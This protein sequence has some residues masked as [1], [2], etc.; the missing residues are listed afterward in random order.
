MNFI[1]NEKYVHKN[2]K[3]YTTIKNTNRNLSFSLIIL[4]NTKL[5]CQELYLKEILYKNT[6][7]NPIL[8]FN[9]NNIIRLLFVFKYRV[10][11]KYSS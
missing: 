11:F 1:Y 5:T 10:S 7:G 2:L 9:T 6:I 4:F 3:C 8:L